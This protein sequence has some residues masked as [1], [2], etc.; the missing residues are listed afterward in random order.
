[1]TKYVWQNFALNIPMIAE[2]NETY[3]RGNVLPH[4]IDEK[5]LCCTV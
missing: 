4:P 3:L 2:T 1:M 5:R